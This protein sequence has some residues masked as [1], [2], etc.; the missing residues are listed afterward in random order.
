[1]FPLTHTLSVRQKNKNR[2]KS[3]PLSKLRR[4]FSPA[5]KE[6][7]GEAFE[8]I[9]SVMKRVGII[10]FVKQ[11]MHECPFAMVWA[12]HLRTL[13]VGLRPTGLYCYVYRGGKG[14]KRPKNCKIMFYTS[15]RRS[16]SVGYHL[17]LGSFSISCNFFSI[18]VQSKLLCCHNNMQNSVLLCQVW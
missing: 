6:P 9:G 11:A 4:W 12:L 8:H 3:Q 10:K 5:F 18:K 14:E 15:Q 2:F 17:R 13:R 1:M 7:R 16:G